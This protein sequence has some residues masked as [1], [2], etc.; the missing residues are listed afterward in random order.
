MWI[1]FVHVGASCIV[2]LYFASPVPA[3]CM[4]HAVTTSSQLVGLRAELQK[5]RAEVSKHGPGQKGIAGREREAIRP[6]VFSA[7]NAG[8]SGRAARDQEQHQVEERTEEKARSVI[9]L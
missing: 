6:K 2:L 4:C 5:K 1:S 9:L 7:S 3:F 8:V